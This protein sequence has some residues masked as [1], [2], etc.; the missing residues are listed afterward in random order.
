MP[1]I[2][3]LSEIKSE[4]NSDPSIKIAVLDGPVDL[5]HPCFYT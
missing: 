5:T 2:V 4:T 3:G 1:I